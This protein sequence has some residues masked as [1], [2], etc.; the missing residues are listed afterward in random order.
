MKKLSYNQVVSLHYEMIM[1]TGGVEGIRDNTLLESALNA[2][3]QG[4][5]D[6]YFYPTIQQKGARLGYGLIKNH[7]FYDGNKRIGAHVM[8]IFLEL[9]GVH[10]TY[11]QEELIDIVLQIA[12]DVKTFDDL[13]QWIY[14]HEKK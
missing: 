8:L 11:S 12:R 7:A 10:L 2:P 3:F 1:E 6:T 14:Q 4:Y 9:N 5:Q 13:T